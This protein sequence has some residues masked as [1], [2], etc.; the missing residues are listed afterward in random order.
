MAKKSNIALEDIKIKKNNTIKKADLFRIEN[1]EKKLES[2]K[3][4]I[5]E[6]NILNILKMFFASKDEA[7][8]K[9]YYT[10]VK[11]FTFNIAFEFLIFLVQVK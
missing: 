1:M 10:L 9:Y 11:L 5:F 4:N 7:K 3:Q 8:N 2:V 6:F